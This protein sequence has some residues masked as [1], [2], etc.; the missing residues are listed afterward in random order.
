MLSTFF[1]LFSGT[2]KSLAVQAYYHSMTTGRF[3]V[4][5]IDIYV[6]KMS[7]KANILRKKIVRQQKACNGSLKPEHIVTLNLFLFVICSIPENV[8]N[9]PYPWK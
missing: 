1:F 2:E 3:I 4:T 9:I 8:H 5:F 7:D 6:N